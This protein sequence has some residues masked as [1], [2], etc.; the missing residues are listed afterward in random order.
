[1]AWSTG[2]AAGLAAGALCGGLIAGA[3][4][5]TQPIKST[6]KPADIAFADMPGPVK[7][8]LKSQTAWLT[9]GQAKVFETG[10]AKIYVVDADNGPTAIGAYV[11]NKGVLLNWKR[12]HSG[13]SAVVPQ[14]VKD[15]FAE[16]MP[17]AKLLGYQ[18]YDSVMYIYNAI[19]EKDG[20]GYRLSLSSVSGMEIEELPDWQMNAY[21]RTLE[22][23]ENK[24]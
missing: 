8:Y 20:K 9:D 1:M 21:K 18:D 19:M 10:P 13:L 7:S 16:A 23:N 6:P 5:M 4:A 2:F 3:V 15:H 24:P 12:N 22:K 17:D 11:T 14:Q